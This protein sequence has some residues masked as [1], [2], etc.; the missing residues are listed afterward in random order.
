MSHFHAL[1]GR[2][3]GQKLAYLPEGYHVVLC[4]DNHPDIIA[5]HPDYKREQFICDMI[6][7]L[8]IFTDYETAVQ[9]IN[10][11]RHGMIRTLAVTVL[12]SILYVN[13]EIYFSQ[14]EARSHV[15]KR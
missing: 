8:E 9:V 1:D 10:D 4:L 2:F 13:E 14:I 3:V 6:D 11:M 12:N 15:K 7:G 5:C